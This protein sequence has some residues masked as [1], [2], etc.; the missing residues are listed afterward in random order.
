MKNIQTILSAVFV[1]GAL[2]ACSSGWDQDPLA[3]KNAK[4]QQGQEEPTKDEKPKGDGSDTV[5]LTTNPE[6]FSF[7]EGSPGDFTF[8]ARVLKT[9]FK[10]M[11]IINN[12]SEFPGAS[13]DAN[14]GKFSWNPPLGTVSANAGDNEETKILKVTVIGRHPTL[15]DITNDFPV[16]IKV[17]KILNAPEIFSVS[18][19]MLNLREG[20]FANIT[21]N[22]RDKDAGTA[23]SSWPMIQVLPTLGYANLSQ[24]VTVAQTTAA[25]NGVFSVTLKVDLTGAELTKKKASYGFAVQAISQFQRQS[26]NQSVAV[27]VLTSFATLQSTWFGSLDFALGQKDEYQFIIFD[28][29]EEIVVGKPTFS[30]VPAGASF[31]C[32]EVNKYRQLCKMIWAPDFTAVEGA[33]TV[34]ADV[35]SRNEDLSDTQTKNQSF[36]LEMNVSSAPPVSPVSLKGGN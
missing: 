5:R 35:V 31:D 12:L 33:Y 9:G 28:P 34:R 32:S 6:L 26:R 15:G 7:Q 17:S 8:N 29:K 4:F 23:P 10:P 27:N 20:D 30:N 11:I 24:F 21:I 36:N 16:G 2:A 14:S 13:F 19:T 25:G 3:N 22:V 18:S 1:V